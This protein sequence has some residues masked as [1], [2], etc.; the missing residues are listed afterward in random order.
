MQIHTPFFVCTIP[1]YSTF[2]DRLVKIDEVFFCFVL[3]TACALVELTVISRAVPAC[4]MTGRAQEILISR[5]VLV[6]SIRGLYSV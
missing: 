3:G 2:H 5:T 1:I 4:L 6:Y